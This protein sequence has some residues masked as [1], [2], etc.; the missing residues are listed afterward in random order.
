MSDTPPAVDPASTPSQDPAPSA[1]PPVETPAPSAA[2]ATAVSDP[3]P[4]AAPAPAQAEAP[5]SMPENWRSLMS[6]ENKKTLNQL[7][8]YKT[9]ADMA[10]ALIEAKQKIR[11]GVSEKLPENPTDEQIAAYR[12]QNG[13]P[14]EHTGYELALNDGLVIGEDD[15]PIID[16]VLQAMHG[17]N[18]SP[19]TVNATVNAYYTMQEQAYADREVKDNSDRT[20]AVAALKDAWGAD[21]QANQ[22]AVVSLLN[23][24]PEGIR[25]ELQSARLPNGDALFNSPDFMEWMAGVS[26]KSNPAATVMPNANNPVQAMNDE[27][28]HIENTMKNEPNKYWGDPAMQKRY[29]ELLGAKESMR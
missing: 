3:A 14:A 18:A 15:K 2:P 9:P 27:L 25:E 26:R 10:N 1:A 8:R 29:N 12:E 23:T 7:E 21:Y 6:G 19:D 22:N 28:T 13:I 17:T 24:V 4:T 5:Q 20:D 11:E 16:S